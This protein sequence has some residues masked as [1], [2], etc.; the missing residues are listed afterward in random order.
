MVITEACYRGGAKKRRFERVISMYFPRFPFHV[1]CPFN[2][3]ELSEAEDSM[4]L[5]NIYLIP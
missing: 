4:R 2:L 3:E 5:K 1:S